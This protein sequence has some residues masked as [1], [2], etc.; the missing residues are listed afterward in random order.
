MAGRPGAVAPFMFHS[1]TN[2]QCP[3]YLGAP[4]VDA[5]RREVGITDDGA[6]NAGVVLALAPQLGA[7]N[8]TNVHRHRI[9]RASARLLSAAVLL[10][11]VLSRRL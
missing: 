9:L 10:A 3:S 5:G 4:G 2:A 8:V 1:N 7:F 11:G 6:M